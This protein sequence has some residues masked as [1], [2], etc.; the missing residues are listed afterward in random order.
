VTQ[1][2]WRA[3]VDLLLTVVMA[4]LVAWIGWGLYRGTITEPP[5]PP[6]PSLPVPA[7]PLSLEGAFLRGNP[8]APVVLVM[9]TDFECPGCRLFEHEAAPILQ[10]DFIDTGLVALA[11]RPYPL[12][13]RG[14]AAMGEAALARC[15]GR[16]ERF[17]EA[18]R[19]LFA[20]VGK[21]PAEKVTAVAMAT[22]LE[23]DA[24][25]GCVTAERPAVERALVEA[26][27]LGVS[28]TPSFFAGTRDAS[29]I[30]R[31]VVAHTGV[32]RGS[33]WLEDLLRPV[34][35]AARP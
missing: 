10:R 19:E 27:G 1:S 30:V 26:R 7:E 6:P 33:Q 34:V 16:Q 3:R 21:T 5:P 15:A 24:L 25:T 22:G 4:G 23:P 12:A 31:A 14:A 8:E 20:S 9:Y 29:G 2:P 32:S 11:V 17:W 28:G 13:N 35:E 18:Y